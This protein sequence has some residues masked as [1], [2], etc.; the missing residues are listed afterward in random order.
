MS[1][2]LYRCP[3]CGYSVNH[4]ARNKSITIDYLSD[5]SM[6]EIAYIHALSP[7]RTN[8][9]FHRTIRRLKWLPSES[10]VAEFFP[11]GI[12]QYER[13]S[14]CFHWEPKHYRLFAK[15]LIPLIEELDW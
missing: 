15:V 14:K 10:E 5:N 9:I 12:E 3:S 11:G 8:Q 6:K 4:V 1:K 13:T 7:A 2:K